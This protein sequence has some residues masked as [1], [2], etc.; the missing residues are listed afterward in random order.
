MALT[1]IQASA[2]GPGH[3]GWAALCRGVPYP[4]DLSSSGSSWGWVGRQQPKFRRPMTL[5][6]VLPA[7]APSDQFCGV[8]LSGTREEGL[9]QHSDVFALKELRPLWLE[10]HREMRAWGQGWWSWCAGSFTA[11]VVWS[12]QWGAPT[13]LMP[14][15]APQHKA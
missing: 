3:R 4:A 10:R 14:T 5:R 9:A 15:C 13:S 11:F 7:W 6:S 8:V 2:Q 12:P 1:E